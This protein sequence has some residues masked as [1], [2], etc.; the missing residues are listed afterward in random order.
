MPAMGMCHAWHVISCLACVNQR[1][2]PLAFVEGNLKSRHLPVIE[3]L[4]MPHA[5]R[6][7]FLS[8]KPLIKR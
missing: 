8:V 4:V 1:M 7:H 3:I 2:M 6:Y 5:L